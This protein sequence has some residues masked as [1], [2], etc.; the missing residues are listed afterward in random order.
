MNTV[1]RTLLCLL[2]AAHR[3]ECFFSLY[4][5][6]MDLSR[7]FSSVKLGSTVDEGASIVNTLGQLRELALE[8][9]VIKYGGHAMGSSEARASFAQDIGGAHPRLIKDPSVFFR[10]FVPPP[11]LLQ[12][13]YNS[14]SRH[15]INQFIFAALLQAA[16]V[17]VVVVHGGGPMIA[18]LLKRLDIP[19]KFVNGMRVTD[20]AT[21]RGVFFC[22]QVSF[23]QSYLL[24]A[25]RHHAFF[26][27]RLQKWFY[28]AS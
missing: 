4:G 15:H 3:V 1:I 7:R 28:R 25:T 27:W 6:S 2:L 21:V 13:I 10:C 5:R 20:E 11:R 8:T 12:G 18:D 14:L 24:I 9:V 23:K 22:I 26:R 16:S 19:T 17:R